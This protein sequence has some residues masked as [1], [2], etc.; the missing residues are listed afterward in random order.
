[1]TKSLATNLIAIG[2]ILV[3]HFIPIYSQHI[4]SIGHF[5]LSGALT[6]WLAIH[7]LFEKVPGLYGSGVIPSRFTEFKATIKSLIMEQ[8]FTPENI[9]RFFSQHSPEDAEKREEKRFDALV[10]TLNYDKIFTELL[11]VVQ[12][13]SFG[14][15][16]G[17]FG[18]VQALLP[19]KD[20][21][22]RR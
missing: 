15:M 11:E 17:M 19:L 13:S 9:E 12:N 2:I 21:L 5:A 1:M 8:F 7:M 10:K 20:D 16:L 14:G 3:G 6:N 4:L 22:P 18:G